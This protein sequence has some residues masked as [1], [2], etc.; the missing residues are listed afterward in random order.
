[1]KENQNTG[2]KELNQ[3]SLFL[4]VRKRLYEKLYCFQYDVN[5]FEARAG[6]PAT[7]HTY[8]R[9]ESEEELL[10]AKASIEQY[11][12]KT[13]FQSV[14]KRYTNPERASN[15]FFLYTPEGDF[16][17]YTELVTKPF[18]DNALNTTIHVEEGGTFCVDLYLFKP[19]RAHHV[20]AQ[21]IRAALSQTREMGYKAMYGLI[22][23]NNPPSLR[24]AYH[25]GGEVTACL[26][27]FFPARPKWYMQKKLKE[28]GPN[29]L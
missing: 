4:K 10:K 24:N 29:L 12:S 28:H 18:Y 17:G 7:G 23:E 3:K 21:I 20:G 9:V 26:Y 2:Y 27:Q 6:I 1:M 25:M 13:K 11:I 14:Y 8:K 5:D 22:N 16:C 15:F 19:Y